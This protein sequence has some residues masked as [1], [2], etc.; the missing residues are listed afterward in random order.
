MCIAHTLHRPKL[1]LNWRAVDCVVQKNYFTVKYSQTHGRSSCIISIFFST[2]N[3]GRDL[4]AGA[5]VKPV[6]N[7]WLKWGQ[8]G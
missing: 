7:H 2:S 4:K 5:E 8:N 6:Q 3:L 1:F